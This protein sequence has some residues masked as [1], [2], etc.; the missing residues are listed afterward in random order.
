PG[1]RYTQALRNSGAYELK[2]QTASG[3]SLRLLVSEAGNVLTVNTRVPRAEVPPT[4]NDAL[5]HWVKGFATNGVERSVRNSGTQVW[6]AFEGK[7]DRGKK[8]RVEIQADGRKI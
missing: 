2:G 7:G 3:Q 5:N 4:V 8:T 1:A 6:Y